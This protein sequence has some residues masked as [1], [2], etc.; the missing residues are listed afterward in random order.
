MASLKQ[1]SQDWSGDLV[2]E[3]IEAYQKIQS[4]VWISLLSQETVIQDARNL[5][6]R[7]PDRDTLPPL[8][9]IPFS[10]KDN[11]DIAGIATTTACPPLARVPSQSAPGGIFIGKTNLEQL[12][13]G[14]TGCRSPYGTLSSVYHRDYI[15][16]GSSSGSC[17]SVA[18]SLVS[19][20][21]G[22]D[23]AGSGRLPA[24]FNGI[25]GWKP[26]KGTVSAAGVTPACQSQDCVAVLA[27]NVEDAR[28]VWHVIKGY[29]EN[30]IYAKPE[31]YVYRSFPAQEMFTF[32]IPSPE[33]LAVCSPPYRRMFD[34]T[35]KTMQ[36][37]GGTLKPIDWLPFENAGKLLY[38]G[39]F[40]AERLAGLPKGWLEASKGYLHPVIR[41]IFEGAAR[42]E[43][44]AIQVFRDLHAQQLYTRQAEKMFQ[45]NA[46]GISVL[47]VPT[48]PTHY[49][50]S[51]VQAEPIAK[52]S[53]LGHFAHFANVVDLCAVALPAST[54]FAT[55]LS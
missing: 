7:F 14:M 28:A 27:K 44:T 34:D 2:F 17:V 48:A 18:A 35:V 12:A 20:S 30:D 41:E 38:E 47:L 54:Y 52:N 24:A 51:E 49:T 36:A 21:M 15:V 32:G 11:I 13:T 26:T 3:R 40:V 1:P 25:V 43:T 16:G 55:E 37:I 8:F 6:V 19:F 39:T 5:Q 23:T 33:A 31:P 22:S 46:G 42:R 53:A 4:S 29:D 45:P 9:G 10:I 50:I